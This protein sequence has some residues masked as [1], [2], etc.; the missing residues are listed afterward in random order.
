MSIEKSN[1][2]DVYVRMQFQAETISWQRFANYLTVNSILFLAWVAIFVRDAAHTCEGKFVMLTICAIGFVGSI[3]WSDLGRRGRLQEESCRE[4]LEDITRRKDWWG[5]GTCCI[6][7]PF[8]PQIQTNWW[9]SSKTILT[10]G[11]CILK[12]E[13]V[14]LALVTLCC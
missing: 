2:Y 7:K 9:S 11:P 13:Y 4:V 8:A 5:E 3:V 6:P 12:V 14:I 10:Y 1:L